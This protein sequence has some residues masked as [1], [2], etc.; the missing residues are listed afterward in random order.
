MPFF[1][2]PD[3]KDINL[4]VSFLSKGVINIYDFLKQ[5][6][7]TKINA[8]DFVYPPLTYFFLGSYQIITKPLLGPEFN[9]WLFDFSG[10]SAATI[11]IFRYLLVLKVPFLIFELLITFLLMK[12]FPDKDQQKKA[13]TFWLFNPLNLYAIYAIGQFDIIPSFLAF[14]S[15]YLWKQKRFPHSGIVLGLGAAFKSFPLLLLPLFLFSKE[16]LTTKIIHAVLAV[17]IYGLSIL[18]FVNSPAFQTD[19]L[20]SNLSKR[21]FINQVSLGNVSISLFLIIYSTLLIFRIKY[22][23]IPLWSY[24][25][26]TLLLV[27]SVT[28]FHPQW[29]VWLT[30]FLTLAFVKAKINLGIIALFIGSY[31]F[32]FLLFNDRFLTTALL[33]PISTIFLEIPSITQLLNTD[34]LN[35][36]KQSAQFLFALI[37]LLICWKVWRLK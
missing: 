27:F 2:H 23:N 31:F 18:P 26:I 5:D 11:F 13:I 19:V 28:T 4:R 21:I 1:F 30:P 35:I 34:K 8:P 20:F 22:Q 15:W 36:F 12:V 37:A 33:S 32:T 29:I 25:L 24:I 7:V 10:K 17:G 16:K 6:S 14:F 9:D 3:I